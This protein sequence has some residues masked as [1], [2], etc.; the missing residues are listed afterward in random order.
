MTIDTFTK[1]WFRRPMKQFRRVDSKSVGATRILALA[2]R[3][4]CLVTSEA[5]S[6]KSHLYYPFKECRYASYQ[7]N[8]SYFLVL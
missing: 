5:K 1:H 7:L 8:T 4:F 6:V 2:E 3:L